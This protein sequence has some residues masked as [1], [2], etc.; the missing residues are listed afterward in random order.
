MNLVDMIELI[1]DWFAATMRHDDGNI[2]KS[3]EINKGRFHMDE[4]TV[5]LLKNTVDTYFRGFKHEDY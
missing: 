1:C 2:D 5:S 4:Q 3:L